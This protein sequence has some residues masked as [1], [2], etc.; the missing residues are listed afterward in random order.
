MYKKSFVLINFISRVDLKNNW[1][2]LK[3]PIQNVLLTQGAPLIWKVESKGGEKWNIKLE[4]EDSFQSSS[5]EDHLGQ[6]AIPGPFQ[7]FLTF[8]HHIESHSN[9]S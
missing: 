4:T 3:E 5:Q 8:I 9:M 6:L 1:F 2:F 7:G